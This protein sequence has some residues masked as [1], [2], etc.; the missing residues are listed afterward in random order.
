MIRKL[1]TFLVSLVVAFSLLPVMAASAAV[2]AT[3]EITSDSLLAPTSS[4][5]SF[6]VEA[7]R[8]SQD[9]FDTLTGGQVLPANKVRIVLPPGLTLAGCGSVEGWS[10]EAVNTQFSH[11]V[12]FT[13]TSGGLAAGETQAFTFTSPV[14][15]PGSADRS[16][17]IGIELSDDG[18]L[19][20]TDA[21]PA[22]DGALDLVT[23]ILQIVN[24]RILNRFNPDGYPGTAL[25]STALRNTETQIVRVAFDV[26][27]YGT[28]QVTI[29]PALNVP[30]EETILV[31]AANA[32]VAPRNQAATTFTY[33]VRLGTADGSRISSWSAGA[34]KVGDSGTFADG[35]A[36]S[37]IEVE[38]IV[39]LTPVAG[40]FAPAVIPVKGT[41]EFSLQVQKDQ[42][43]G[44]TGL[45]GTLSL[46]AD[47][48]TSRTEVIGLEFTGASLGRGAGTPT[49]DFDAASFDL[50]V[51][52]ELVLDGTLELTGTDDNGLPYTQ[53]IP[54]DNILT[55]DALAP[56]LNITGV[57]IV[58]PATQQ[59]RANGT[60]SITI[61]GNLQ[62][63]ADVPKVNAAAGTPGVN[64]T[65]RMPGTNAV[66]L[67]PTFD[68]NNFTV[69]YDLT[70]KTSTGFGD[71]IVSGSATDNALNQS[72]SATST[73]QFDQVVPS[74]ETFAIAF[75][76]EAT[77]DTTDPVVQVS[78]VEQYNDPK[79]RGGCLPTNWEV[80]N[81]IVTEVRFSD[82][83]ACSTLQGRTR[84]PDNVRILIL[85][86]E[87]NPE[88]AGSVDYIANPPLSLLSNPVIDS[89]DNRPLEN[90][91]REIIS[92]VRPLI[93][94]ILDITRDN[95]FGAPTDDGRESMGLFNDGWFT[96]V[97]DGT[98]PEVFFNPAN[99]AS[100]YILRVYRVDNGI[101]TLIGEDTGD[102]DANPNRSVVLDHG[103]TGGID[104]DATGRVTTL[105]A[106]LV[107]DPRRT[108][109]DSSD[110]LLSDVL[111][112]TITFDDEA[113][114][115]VSAAVITDG[116]R[117]TF[118]EA[119]AAGIDSASDWYALEHNADAGDGNPYFPYGVDAVAPAAN[120]DLASR[121]LTVDLGG[122]GTFA[123]VDF[124]RVSGS[125]ADGA[126]YEDFAGNV[127]TLTDSTL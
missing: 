121:D 21:T 70:S 110:D 31:D 66:Q 38:Q 93:P 81:A 20:Y 40:G 94:E 30:A 111:E 26:R 1:I 24:L 15:A 18:G 88:N 73:L 122:N 76:D 8:P 84:G 91:T 12:I 97:A 107:N 55:I 63:A 82:G 51:T 80:D 120:G 69:T 36:F 54:L 116:V 11:A 29:D 43:Q 100:T 42:L 35:R 28:G 17:T 75:V 113:P 96:N 50:N 123:G 114:R 56:I 87:I 126:F 112:F 59:T 52:G 83:S 6:T 4:P 48:D 39:D 125:E 19:T 95:L 41:R 22:Y 71:I 14:A 68:G 2:T 67:Q 47:G 10:C 9:F 16:E 53:T 32:T 64:L 60:D 57:T 65:V 99:I 102:A 33:D 117:A 103:T 106:Q 13:A 34:T 25:G 98:D 37:D 108:P 7:T 105:R 5:V 74:L 3:A 44:I 72:P 79:V 49:L 45:N 119:L 61:T 77:F 23:R 118:N 58:D 86:R 90:M 101:Q 124:F 127:H 115:L 62:Q 46:F 109:N 104:T 27:N 89:A 92:G 78:W 85:D